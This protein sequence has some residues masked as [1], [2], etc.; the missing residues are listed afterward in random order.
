MVPGKISPVVVESNQNNP[1]NGGYLKTSHGIK[2]DYADTKVGGATD[3]LA[4]QAGS[5]EKF[6]DWRDDFFAKGYTVVKGAIPRERAIQYR[7]RAMDWFQKFNFGFD[8]HDK[9]TWTEDHL[10]ITMNAGMIMGYCAT[11][12]KWVWEARS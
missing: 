4:K 12:E 3:I 9:S 11:H 7:E 5:Q 6:G 10:P 8:I 2:H 1:Y